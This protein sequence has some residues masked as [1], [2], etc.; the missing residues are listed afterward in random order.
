M[1]KLV[2]F[3]FALFVVSTLVACM[4]SRQPTAK[5]VA[6]LE[7]RSG[8]TAQ[9]VVTFLEWPNGS[10]DIEISLSNVPPGVHGFHIH[11]NGNCSA[12]DGSS[13]GDHFSPHGMP[14]GAPTD[15]Q[16]HAGDLGNVTANRNGRVSTTVRS[17][18]LSA[19]EGTNSVA[20]RAV[21]LHADPDDLTSQPS[22][23]AGARIACG[24]INRLPTP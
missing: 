1:K 16:K 6:T 11:E 8:S 20:N 14:H 4:S 12:A 5:A 3:T 13:A 24:V 15:G 7:G 18:V 19:H 9:G 17:H 2:T 22:G 21:V 23:N 10:V